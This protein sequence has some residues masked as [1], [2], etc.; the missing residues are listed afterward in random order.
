MPETLPLT[1]T[2]IWNYHF[3]FPC[4]NSIKQESL[5]KKLNTQQKTEVIFP[6]Q[7]L[8][9]GLDQLILNLGIFQLD[10]FIQTEAC[11]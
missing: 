2:F 8:P 1:T 3:R 10:I 4:S 7:E 9:S 11:S 6:T 5:K